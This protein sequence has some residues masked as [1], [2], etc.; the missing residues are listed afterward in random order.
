MTTKKRRSA[1]PPLAASPAKSVADE[2][3]TLRQVFDSVVASYSARIHHEL[4]EIAQA[5]NGL[6]LTEDGA[7]RHKNGAA[8]G[9]LRDLRDMLSLLRNL[10]VRPEKGRRKDLKKI[11]TTVGDLQLLIEHWPAA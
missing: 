1:S 5:I 3:R 4:D 7:L 6:E 9:N 11:D 2:L 10:Q 8:A